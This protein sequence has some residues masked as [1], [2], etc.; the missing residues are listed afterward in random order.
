MNI[1]IAGAKAKTKYYNL[2]MFVYIQR[3]NIDKNIDVGHDKTKNITAIP[4]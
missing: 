4:M 2:L 1:T 3:L